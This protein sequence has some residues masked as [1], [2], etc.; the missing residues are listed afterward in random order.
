MSIERSNDA[1][2]T[3]VTFRLAG[4]EPAGPVSV[5]GS[6][7]D[8]T[9]GAHPLETDPDGSRSVTVRVPAGT[10]AHFRYL[11]ADGHWFDDPQA[12][13]VTADGSVLRAAE[14]LPA[15]PESPGENTPESPAEHTPEARPE[16][17]ADRLDAVA[18]RIDAAKDAARDLTERD[19]LDPET[20]DAGR[21]HQESGP[22]R[23]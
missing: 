8:W 1:D 13:E 21:E 22:A 10:T 15:A 19:V 7:N 6:F 16:P 17:D 18:E 20:L 3:T 9:P 4:D 11:A 2:G 14:S 12:D 23:N 5:V